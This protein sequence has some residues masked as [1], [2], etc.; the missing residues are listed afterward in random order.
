MYS[1]IH[2]RKKL[3]GGSW[4]K[5]DS[6]KIQIEVKQLYTNYFYLFIFVI[7]LQKKSVP[8]AEKNMIPHTWLLGFGVPVRGIAKTAMSPLARAATA[9]TAKAGEF[10]PPNSWSH[11][12]LPKDTTIYFKHEKYINSIAQKI[13][14]LCTTKILP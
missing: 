4:W 11:G 2:I 10:P 13:Q 3:G 5:E 12:P 1:I 14:I 8:K 7:H 6:I 9:A